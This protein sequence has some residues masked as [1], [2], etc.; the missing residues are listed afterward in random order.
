[1]SLFTHQLGQPGT[2]PVGPPLPRF[3]LILDA[4]LV[5]CGSVTSGWAYVVKR[6]PIMGSLQAID[7][8]SLRVENLGSYVSAGQ[9]SIGKSKCA[10]IKK[11]LSPNIAVT[12]RQDQWEFFKIWL[13]HG[14]AV[15]P[16][17]IAGLDNVTTRHSVQRLWRETMIDMA[18]GG[19]ETQVIVKYRNGDGQCLVNALVVPPD[20]IPWAQ[21]LGEAT[22]LNPELIVSDPTG[23]I[24]QADVD[25]G[26]IDNRPSLQSAIGKTRC[27]YVNRHTLEM[28]E[29]DRDF[30]PA[31]P[32]VTAFSGVIAA[33]ETMKSL[34]RV[35]HENSLHY[36]MSFRSGLLRALQM[37]C[38]PE[39]EC[40][41]VS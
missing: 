21:G 31:A 25:R 4:F 28:E 20:E 32:F 34:M 14:V 13:R 2:L 8:Q 33:A 27:G 38:N 39:C 24:T 5:G 35:R 6:L 23:E 41:K 9:S 16:L 26:P 18:A 37:K 10:V 3:P 15:P 7:R 11:F 40:Q 12:D 1:M 36:Q 29:F 19:L 22:G 30:E 17:I